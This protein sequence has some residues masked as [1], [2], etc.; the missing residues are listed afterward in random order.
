VDKSRPDKLLDPLLDLFQRSS[1]LAPK[2]FHA[3]LCSLRR[4]PAKTMAA[5]ASA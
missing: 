3:E 2:N 5:T 1:E 4:A